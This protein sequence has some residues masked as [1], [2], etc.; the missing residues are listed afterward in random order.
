MKKQKQYELHHFIA[1][2]AQLSNK[3]RAAARL[4]KDH[5]QPVEVFDT[6]FTLDFGACYFITGEKA[7]GV[8]AF[9]LS[10]LLENKHTPV[11][12]VSFFRSSIEIVSRLNAMYPKLDLVHET[13][14]VLPVLQPRNF[15]EFM[16]LLHSELF[17]QVKIILISSLDILPWNS[18]S[19]V[20]SFI[21]EIQ[22]F[23]KLN[24]KL[25][26]FS[27]VEPRGSKKSDKREFNRLKHIIQQISKAT[28]TVYRPE[29]HGILEIGA[30]KNYSAGKGV[31]T[32]QTATQSTSHILKFDA[33]IGVWSSEFRTLNSEL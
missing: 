4:A 10:L 5:N 29:Y 13:M 32:I 12:I 22:A 15:E 25:I 18:P 3:E 1:Q 20:E 21:D 19:I 26:L 2:S 30:E 9:S 14:L 33:A 6:G 23:A 7:M 17:A 24:G 11:S 31:V 8:T 27:L 28:I 16:E